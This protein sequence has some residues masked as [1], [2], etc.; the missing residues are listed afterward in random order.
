V[1]LR[2]ACGR[3][4]SFAQMPEPLPTCTQCGVCDWQHVDVPKKPYTITV[5]DRRFLRSLRIVADDA[6]V[7]DPD[8]DMA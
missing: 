5:N 6:T 4:V 7:D 2:C 1:V 3:R 8:D